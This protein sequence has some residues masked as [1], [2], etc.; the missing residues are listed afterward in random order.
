MKPSVTQSD[1]RYLPAMET[2]FS[3]LVGEK[4]ATRLY[5]LLR[6]GSTHGRSCTEK[7]NMCGIASEQGASLPLQEGVQ[8]GVDGRDGE[9]VKCP[10]APHASAWHS[11]RKSGEVCCA[12]KLTRPDVRWYH[13]GRSQAAKRSQVL[14]RS[15]HIIMW[16][17]LTI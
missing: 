17:R 15:G 9:V 8:G 12:T 11:G 2:V 1:T 16:L 4:R 5:R 13:Y 10:P 3:A 14:L 7:K 6:R